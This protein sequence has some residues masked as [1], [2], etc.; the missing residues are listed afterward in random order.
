M[1][2]VTNSTKAQQQRLWLELGEYALRRWNLQ[3]DSLRLL[4]YGSKVIIRVSAAGADYVLRM[5][6]PERVNVLWLRSELT[7]LSLIRRRTD[8]LAPYP[9]PA[10]FDGGEQSL[11]ELRHERL[12]APSTAYATLFEFIEGDVKSARDLGLV[13]VARVGEYLGKLHTVGQ[14]S[15]PAAFDGPR[16]DWEGL[17]G[18]NSPYAS[19]NERDLISDEQRA[20]LDELAVRLRSP[21]SKLSSRDDATGLIHADLLAKNIVFRERTIAALDFEF[22]GRGYFLFDLAPL[23]WQLKGERAADYS[24]LEEAIWTGYTSVRPVADG[25]RELLEPFIAARQFASI[26]WLLANLENP[27][28]GEKT[29]SLIADRCRELEGFLETGIMQRSTPTL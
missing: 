22:C 1:A 7:W 23:L 28:I 13:D 10:P 9:I 3:A 27:A 18:D 19:P 29:P 16:L 5:H 14:F 12:P 4:A 25:D 26:R 11:I 20:I 17:F 8:L 2:E 24:E 15:P 6:R 21:L